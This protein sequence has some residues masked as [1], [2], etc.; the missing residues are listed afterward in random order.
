MDRTLPKIASHGRMARIPPCKK[1]I[2]RRGN[3]IPLTRRMAGLQPW[4]RGRIRP[5]TC[6]D[7]AAEE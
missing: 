1:T 7:Y 5:S 4:R 2:A 6:R 3:R